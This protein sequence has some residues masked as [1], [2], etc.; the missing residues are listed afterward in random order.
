MI[1]GVRFLPFRD[2]LCDFVDKYKVCLV[3]KEQ[4]DA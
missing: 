1:G 4:N 2:E 3:S